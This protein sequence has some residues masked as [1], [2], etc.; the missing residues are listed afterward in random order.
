[1]LI[2]PTKD[3]FTIVLEIPE[4]FNLIR[5]PTLFRG[6]INFCITGESFHID[7]AIYN[8]WIDKGPICEETPEPS[9]MTSADRIEVIY[10]E[11]MMYYYPKVYDLLA[12]TSCD[13]SEYICRDVISVGSKSVS[14]LMERNPLCDTSNGRKATLPTSNASLSTFKENAAS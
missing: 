10:K 8:T 1:M 11:V 6:I 12:N 7:H 3:T 13:L 5:D 14:I 9:D 2:T 4:N